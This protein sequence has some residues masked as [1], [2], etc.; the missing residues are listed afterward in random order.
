[1]KKVV[2]RQ[3]QSDMGSGFGVYECPENT[4]L[5]EFLKWFKDHSSE[6][7]VMKIYY[8][9]GEVLRSFDYDLHNNN[10]FYHHLSWE[11]KLIIKE[12]KFEYCFMSEDVYVYLK[13]L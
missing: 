3:Q 5:G 13:G 9:D 10:Q 11:E 1:M 2:V 8:S 7:G 6:W 12:V 4:T